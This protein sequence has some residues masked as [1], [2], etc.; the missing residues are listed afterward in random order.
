MLQRGR[1]PSA[2]RPGGLTRD[3]LTSQPCVAELENCA[4][5]EE[6]VHLFVL[7]RP[8]QRATDEF[9]N[10]IS[11]RHLSEPCADE[12]VAITDGN[13]LFPF[14]REKKKLENGLSRV[15]GMLSQQGVKLRFGFP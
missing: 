12:G 7:P 9:P 8:D 14:Q 3:R 6:C 5:T 2:N 13:H 4:P 15:V 11:D 10:L 1:G